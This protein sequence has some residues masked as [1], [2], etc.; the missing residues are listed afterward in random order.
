M[1]KQANARPDLRPAPSRP[2]ASAEFT[3]S[4]GERVFVASYADGYLAVIPPPGYM[5]CLSPV[6]SAAADKPGHYLFLV[7]LTEDGTPG[8]YREGCADAQGL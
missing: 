4:N 8:T 6:K 7:P 2:L 5:L 3:M 1:S